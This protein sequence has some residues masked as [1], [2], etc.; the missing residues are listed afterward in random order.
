MQLDLAPPNLPWMEENA[1]FPEVE[2]AW[3]PQTEAPGLLAAG[4]GLDV[5]RLV[6]AYSS[7]IFPWFSQGQPVLW[8]SPDPRMVLQIS[9]F[10]LQRSLRKTLTR[11]GANPNFDLR[12]DTAFDRVIQA[13]AS[14]P[15]DGQNG[16]WIVPDMVQAYQALHR[17]GFAH[18][19]ETWLEGELVAGLYF[20]NLGHAVFGESMFSTLSD[21]SKM[22][23]AALVHVCQKHGIQAIDCQQNTPHLASLG[24][25]MMSRVNFIEQVQS[26]L[27]GH[28]PDWKN[29]TLDWDA[30]MRSQKP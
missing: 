8:W 19:V 16:T 7:G 13:C 29:E 12:F 6:Q 11:Y 17:A 22:A 18:S 1:L 5:P 28:S 2:R 3:G 27:N 24:A 20:V 21:G 25:R 9:D 14:S 15:R 4:A 30:W 10:K 26:A 23:L